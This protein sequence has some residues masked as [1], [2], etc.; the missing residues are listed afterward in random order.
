MDIRNRL[1]DGLYYPGE[2]M[3]DTNKR[4]LGTLAG[5]SI[6]LLSFNRPPDWGIH[7][8][9]SIVNYSGIFGRRR[10][11]QLLVTAILSTPVPSIIV[12]IEPSDI[13]PQAEV[14]THPEV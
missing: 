9:S 8:V 5:L 2:Y 11:R 4:A 1:P 10:G 13:F 3:S 14:S 12:D 6:A 7:E